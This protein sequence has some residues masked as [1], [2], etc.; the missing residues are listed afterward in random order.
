MPAEKKKRGRKSTGTTAASEVKQAAR[1]GRKST[2]PIITEP[3]SANVST[4]SSNFDSSMEE[5]TT[6]VQRKSNIAKQSGDISR[7]RLSNETEIFPPLENNTKRIREQF[8]PSQYQAQNTGGI[9]GEPANFNRVQTQQLQQQHFQQ[10]Q[11][12]YPQ[13]LKQQQYSMY[14]SVNLCIVVMFFLI[15][16]V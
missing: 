13:Q 8:L 2:V 7:K 6:V 16:F 4:D 14:L 15:K 10:P 5:R 3:A 1:R 11:E 12:L 9:Q